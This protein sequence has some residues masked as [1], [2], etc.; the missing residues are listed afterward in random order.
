[1]TQIERVPGGAQFDEEVLPDLVH[2]ALHERPR[3]PH[4]LLRRELENQLG[5]RPGVPTL[6]R[7][8]PGRCPRGRAGHAPAQER[9]VRVSGPTD[10]AEVEGR[11]EPHA[12][13]RGRGGSGDNGRIRRACQRVHWQA[14]NFS[15]KPV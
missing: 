4:V 13:G 14:P 1:M 11:R 6:E 10:G 5:R 9:V 3:A 7:Q 15:S 2:R 12:W 8:R